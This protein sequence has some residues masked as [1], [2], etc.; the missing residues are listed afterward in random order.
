MNLSGFTD[1]AFAGGGTEPANGASRT[2][3]LAAVGSRIL[4]AC[5]VLSCLPKPGQPR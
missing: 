2:T 4:A 3:T 1:G 5:P